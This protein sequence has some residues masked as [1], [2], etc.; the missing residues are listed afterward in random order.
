MESPPS[1]KPK[2]VT[3][4]EL[5]PLDRVTH[6]QLR[7]RVGGPSDELRLVVESASA[8]SIFKVRAVDLDSL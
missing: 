7:Q 4:L 8:N 3:Q 5:G 6:R 1:K 2:N